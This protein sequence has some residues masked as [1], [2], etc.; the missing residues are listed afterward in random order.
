MY[1]VCICFHLLCTFNNV[2]CISILYV[3]IKLSRTTG[4]PTVEVL[5]PQTACLAN[6]GECN[7]RLLDWTTHFPMGP[8]VSTIVSI[9]CGQTSTQIVYTKCFDHTSPQLMSSSTSRICLTF[10]LL[11]VQSL[12]ST[13]ALL[14]HVFITVPHLNPLWGHIMHALS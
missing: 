4:F 9:L 1:A 8:L 6:S 3:Q 13:A 14:Q 11:C 12:P 10:L 7:I 2:K 5:E